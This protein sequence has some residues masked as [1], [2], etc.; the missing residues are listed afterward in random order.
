VVFWSKLPGSS[1]GR[2]KCR[3]RRRRAAGRLRPSRLAAVRGVAEPGL[4]AA[5]CRCTA[6]G[7]GS[8]ASASF[9]PATS[10][11][12]PWL[13]TMLVSE[14]PTR[15]SGRRLVV[16]TWTFS[17]RGAGARRRQTPLPDVA[18][19]STR[20]APPLASSPRL[21]RRGVNWT[22]VAA[23]GTARRRNDQQTP[24]K[25]VY[26]CAP[27]CSRRDGNRRRAKRCPR[28]DASPACRERSHLKLCLDGGSPGF[29]AQAPATVKNARL[30]AS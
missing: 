14:R 8:E 27:S 20:L 5:G 10:C 23:I 4:P 26:P 22:P 17:S 21:S 1:Q 9:H 3:S 12:P 2:R 25:Q 7:P 11:W 29:V 15:P 13:V 19:W 6:R 30:R 24:A 16:V 18:G 28:R